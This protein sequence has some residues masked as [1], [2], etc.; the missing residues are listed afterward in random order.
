MVNV[1]KTV[2]NVEV[3]NGESGDKFAQNSHHEEK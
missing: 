3:Y 2:M 1:V